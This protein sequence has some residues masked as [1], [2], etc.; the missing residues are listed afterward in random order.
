MKLI[1]EK[2]IIMNLCENLKEIRKIK[3]LIQNQII[4]LKEL[5]L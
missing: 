4:Y 2:V 3:N 5:N 1:P